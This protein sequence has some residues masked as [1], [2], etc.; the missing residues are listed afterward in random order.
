MSRLA[1]KALAVAGTA[2]L[3]ACRFQAG[4]D[5]GLKEAIPGLHARRKAMPS[6]HRKYGARIVPVMSSNSM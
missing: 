6:F 4:R 2:L 3:S 5:H 1:Y